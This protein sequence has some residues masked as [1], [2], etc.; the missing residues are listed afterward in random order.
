[1]F[2]THQPSQ[3]LCGWKKSVS[4]WIRASCYFLWMVQLVAQPNLPHLTN[5]RLSKQDSKIANGWLLI[6]ELGCFQC[7]AN[8]PTTLSK[9]PHFDAPDLTQTPSRL[10]SE[11]VYQFIQNPNHSHPGTRMP[12]VME[13]L[14]ADQ[15]AETAHH[16]TAYLWYSSTIKNADLSRTRNAPQTQIKKGRDL[17]TSIGCAACHPLLEAVQED[18]SG[19]L[20]HVKNKYHYSGLQK[21]LLRPQSA[22]KGYRMP[23]FNLNE[24]EASNLTSYLLGTK[25]STRRAPNFLGDPEKGQALFSELSCATCHS[26]SREIEDQ[27]TVIHFPSPDSLHKGCLA[28]MPQ[29]HSPWYGLTLEQKDFIRSAL[30]QTDTSKEPVFQP[31]IEHSLTILNCN[32]CHLRKPLLPPSPDKQLSFTTSGEDLE[33]EGRIPP[34]LDGVGRKLTSDALAST[35][36]GNFPVRPYMNTRMPNWGSEHAALL[37]KLFEETDLQPNE[38]PTPRDAH[39]N[40][41]GRNMWGRTLMGT[42]GLGCIQ[43][44]RL[45][46][47]PSLGIQSMDLMHVSQRLRAP[48]FRDY[49]I[50]PAKFRPGTRMPAFWP[51]GKP[52]INGHGGSTERQ[53]D[54]IWAYL[55]ELDQSRLP[56]GME[57]KGKFDLE[58]NQKPM[59]FRTFMADAGLH[60]IAVGFP[61]QF[62][63][64]FDAQ[65]CQWALAWTGSF[66]D[67]EATWDNRF[68]PL[69]QPL[70]NKLAWFPVSKKHWKRQDDQSS[71]SEMHTR[72][73][74]FR[75]DD[76][77]VPGFHYSLDHTRVED[78]IR[79]LPDGIQR[80]L[81]I[82][83]KAGSFHLLIHTSSV[84]KQKGDRLYQTDQNFLIEVKEGKPQII[85][86]KDHM[87]LWLSPSSHQKTR[88][89]YII[90]T[91]KP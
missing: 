34:D 82:S 1:M 4:L 38:K 46:N 28:D 87:Q 67:A 75:L 89:E 45:R 27:P 36:Q 13:H 77:G 48:W 40:Q 18:T 58:P 53:I 88:L 64:A 26:S 84:I 91:N 81:N 41:V 62:H 54:S 56:K 59:V 90:R 52:S 35:I 14:T 70:G 12:S 68:T 51:D 30:S 50:D 83:K 37:T 32:A 39:E 19:S 44:H 73:Y 71:T 47:N 86:E 2:R 76:E 23:D 8:A 65:S 24:T 16:I 42:D 20:A 17:F 11:F 7:H 10:T 33:D 55:S 31:G 15:K 80:T 6:N 60:A 9:L 29:K 5:A 78:R 72:F 3:N 74:G 66:L 79:A 69:T 85:H 61:Q 21:F 25:P 63:V 22:R 43:C 49:L 57:T